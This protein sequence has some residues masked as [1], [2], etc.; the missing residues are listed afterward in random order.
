MADT[1][2]IIKKLEEVEID[3]VSKFRME[4][5]EDKPLEVF[6]RR[7][8]KKSAAANL[9]QT[10]VAKVEGDRK[11]VGYVS[12]M[13]AEIQLEKSYS[14]TDKVGADK[15]DYQPAVRIARLAVCKEYKRKGAGKSLVEMALGLILVAIAPSVGCRFVILDAKSKSIPFYKKRGFRLLNT[16]ENLQKETPLMFLDLKNLDSEAEAETQTELAEI[17]E[18]PQ[19]QA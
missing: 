7:D 1:N 4:L 17:T 9:T 10:Y 3:Q 6:I 15:Y 18:T 11:V 16:P 5:E 12:I 13:C 19:D 14:I 2:F 8:A